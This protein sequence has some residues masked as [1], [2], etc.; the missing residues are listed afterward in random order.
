M[1]AQTDETVVLSK[2]DYEELKKR[3]ATLSALEAGGVDNWE[4]YSD[5]LN[6]HLP[7]EYKEKEESVEE[8][9]GKDQ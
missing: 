8:I 2:K 5:S 1:S 7:E 6:D 4:W 3:A 9:Y